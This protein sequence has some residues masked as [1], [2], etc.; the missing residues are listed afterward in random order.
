MKN[1]PFLLV[2][3]MP[4]YTYRNPETGE[5]EIIEIYIGEFINIVG[6]A[7]RNVKEKANRK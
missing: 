1:P 6:K 3:C 4:L 2:L 7:K 5:E